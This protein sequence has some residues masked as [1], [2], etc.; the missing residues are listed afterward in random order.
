MNKINHQNP[1]ATARIPPWLWSFDDVFGQ[2]SYGAGV[3]IP[4]GAGAFSV[5]GNYGNEKVKANTQTTNEVAG[6]YAGTGGFDINV[7]GNTHLDAAVI[8]SET[9]QNHLRTGT[10]TVADK[11][12]HS[13]YNASSMNLSASYSGKQTENVIG[14][15]GK[16]TG[17]TQPKMVKDSNGN[18]VQAQSGIKGFNASLPS[19]LSAKDSADSTTRAGIAAG[20]IEI[21]DAAAQQQLTGQT[22]EQTIAGLNRDTVNNSTL[23]NLYEQD[24]AAIQTGFAIGRNLGQ[25]FNSFMDIMVKDMDKAGEKPAKDA[26]GNP[27]LDASGKPM[28]VKQAYDQGYEVAPVTVDGQTINYATRQELWGSGGTGN[29]LA[30]AVV[31]AFSGNVTGGAGELLKNTAINVVRAY[32]ATEIKAIADGFKNPD[33]STNGTSETV[34]GLLHAI[35]GCAGASAT[36]GDC[37]TAAIA[38]GG[39]VA[40]NNAMGALLN[41]DPSTMTEEQKQAYSNLMG[42]LVSGV[43]SAVGGDAVAAQL[44]TKVEEDNNWLNAVDATWKGQ[45]ESKV[46]QLAKDKKDIPLADLQTLARLV[47]KDAKQ[48]KEYH[49]ACAN[50]NSAACHTYINTKINDAV[51]TYYSGG[52]NNWNLKEYAE[53][54][55]LQH[56]T[57][58]AWSA[59]DKQN[60]QNSTQ[61]MTAIKT[62]VIKAPKPAYQP[63]SGQTTESYY[64]SG[65]ALV[66]VANT[67]AGLP[68][69]D[70]YVPA[71]TK[72][73]QI[74]TGLG[75]GS[76]IAYGASLTPCSAACVALGGVLGQASTYTGVAAQA[77]NPDLG[78]GFVDIGQNTI[79]SSV[80][81]KYQW[82]M[83]VVHGLTE[84]V[85]ETDIIE[86]SQNK[87]NEGVNDV[88]FYKPQPW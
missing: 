72:L 55:G 45:L 58:K 33:G 69:P 82:T 67:V 44:A 68:P 71:H 78:K 36:G 41:L 10:L 42:T 48:D 86:E 60:A 28:T 26:S 79:E 35:A 19:V 43:T 81:K 77:L 47:T 15:D 22:T 24:K 62:N 84:L 57:I 20:Q 32:G 23:T 73:D 14:K 65:G 7:K 59:P 53:V 1:K 83:P 6:I 8:A 85:K 37:A 18:M 30:T 52:A 34:R 4:L 88:I 75:W 11:A 46:K 21:T 40:M 27:I 16:P 61:S 66:G 50:K 64:G 5:S 39:T 49:I 2:T 38:S 17:E 87:V 13:D 31:G 12:N 74:S 51:A 80:P 54:V 63:A 25:N 9:D 76:A 29:I 70:P 3:S 56:S